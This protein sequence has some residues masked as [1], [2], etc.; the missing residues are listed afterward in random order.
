[1]GVSPRCDIFYFFPPRALLALLD[2]GHKRWTISG[3]KGR[4]GC[5]WVCVF[6]ETTGEWERERESARSICFVFSALWLVEI[7]G[8]GTLA[9][10]CTVFFLKLAGPSF[11]GFS[12]CL[13]G[14][15]RPSWFQW[16]TA[17]RPEQIPAELSMLM[18]VGLLVLHS[19]PDQSVCFPF[20][21]P[22]LYR[23]AFWSCCCAT[24]VRLRACCV[25]NL[26]VCPSSR[27]TTKAFESAPLIRDCFCFLPTNI[28]KTVD[29][30]VAIAQTFN[31][32]AFLRWSLD[33]FSSSLRDLKSRQLTS[34]GSIF[35]CRR[36]A[37]LNRKIQVRWHN[38][39][40][41]V[42]SILIKFVVMHWKFKRKEWPQSVG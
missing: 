10:V 35:F 25:A 41:F 31:P 39:G 15:T 29:H 32:L 23:C 14:A 3:E 12:S 9:Y 11:Y 27:V 18:V 13:T 20:P 2:D 34:T 36:R 40:W 42:L 7:N 37:D 1:L 8:G 26:R 19:V 5:G 16:T 6:F 17:L 33:W 24:S 4:E 30:F 22:V 38:R 21:S 28:L